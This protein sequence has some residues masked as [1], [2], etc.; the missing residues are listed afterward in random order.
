MEPTRTPAIPTPAA[1]DRYPRAVL[2]DLLT[3]LLDS[4]TAWNAAAGSERQGRLW[5]AE[6]LRLTYGCGA[7]QPY[8]DLVRQAAATVGLP[9]SAPGALEDR[10][11]ALPAWSGAKELLAAL[12][13]H[14][15][16][17]VV[18]NCSRRLG[19]RAAAGG[20]TPVEDVRH[21]ELARLGQVNVWCAVQCL[22]AVLPSMRAAGW[23]RVVNVS[24]RA[25]LG[26]AGRTLYAATKAGLHGMTRT[27]ALE[28]A[29]SGITVNTVS[30][31]PIA[32]AMFH[33]LNPPDSEGT[34]RIVGSVP[35]GRMGSPEEVAHAIAFFVEEGAAFTTGQLLHVCGGL[36]VGAG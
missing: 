16:L 12:K 2:F 26:K 18:T 15:R 3:A 24:S 35:V 5:R 20:S 13:P 10:W 28:L 19:T 6:Y 17:A 8:E 1:G 31:G 33:R 9:A 4:W 29:P 25:A 23:G 27:W 34:A 14:C 21:E 22:Q 32:T 36:T 7:Y 11:D 30:P